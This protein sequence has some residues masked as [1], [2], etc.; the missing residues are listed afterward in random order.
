MKRDGGG[1]YP[2]EVA[3]VAPTVI[4]GIAVQ[5]LSPETR[6]GSADTVVEEGDGGEVAHNDQGL[7]RRT[8]FANEAKH[9]VLRVIAVDPSESGC[10][11]VKLMQGRLGPVE[12]V[13]ILYPPLET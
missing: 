13:Q 2:T 8:S 9:T 4:S 1:L 3:M 5:Y 10:V 11:E 6:K 7:F 12:P